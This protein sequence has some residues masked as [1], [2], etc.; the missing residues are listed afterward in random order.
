MVLI[1][2]YRDKEAARRLSIRARDVPRRGPWSLPQPHLLLE[3]VLSP[4]TLAR[5]YANCRE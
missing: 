2:G 5:R 1:A 3:E 4:K